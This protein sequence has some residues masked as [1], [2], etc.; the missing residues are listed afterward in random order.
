MERAGILYALEPREGLAPLRLGWREHGRPNVSKAGLKATAERH[1][2]RSALG[3]PLGWVARNRFL[4][5]EN[6]LWGCQ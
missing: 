5:H 2:T 6:G 3:G 4:K 1:L